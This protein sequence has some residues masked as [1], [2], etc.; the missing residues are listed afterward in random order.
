MA[1]G[2]V[3]VDPASEHRDR[4]TASLERAAVRLA[5]D[6]PSESAH[7]DDAGTRKLARE[8]ASDLSTVG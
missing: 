2:V 3:V 5:V 6:A 8:V 7:H 1:A 4:E